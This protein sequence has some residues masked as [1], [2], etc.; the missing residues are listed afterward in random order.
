MR[1]IRVWL[2]LWMTCF[3]VAPAYA[4]IFAGG[5]IPL[6]YE[7]RTQLK[8]SNLDWLEY[9]I[10]VLE[11]ARREPLLYVLLSQYYQLKLLPSN[12]LVPWFKRLAGQRPTLIE[13]VKI[14]G[15]LITRPRYDYPAMARAI[16]N[17][18][19]ARQYQEQYA[20]QLRDGVFP[21]QTIFQSKNPTLLA[22]Q[23]AVVYALGELDRQQLERIYQRLQKYSY[24]FPDNSVFAALAINLKN[25]HILEQLF[26]QAVDQYSIN[27]LNYIAEH[28][29]PSFALAI[30]IQAAHHPQ[31]KYY[32]LHAMTDLAK[33]DPAAAQYV[34]Q[35]QVK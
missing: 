11:P 14:D 4:R 9:H 10:P 19:Q 29:T 20:R 17:H 26:S 28:Y 7:A 24:F 23:Q 34:Q 12:Q 16:L 27:A 25:R 1:W 31:I 32:A 21:W 35:Q 6:L 8:A 5:S 15:Y 18:W 3:F 2:L 22:Q 13:H 33:R 30:L